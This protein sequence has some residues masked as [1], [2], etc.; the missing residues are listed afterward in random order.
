MAIQVVRFEHQG[1]RRRVPER[2]D[3]E[4][5]EADPAI[6]LSTRASSAGPKA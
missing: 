6:L 1:W 2:E 5:V 3:E 4:A